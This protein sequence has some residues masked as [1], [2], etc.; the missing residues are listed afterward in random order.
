[1]PVWASVVLCVSLALGPSA[2]AQRVDEGDVGVT[3]VAARRSFLGAGGGVARR[4]GQAR[5]AVS[6]TLGS[7]AGAAAFRFSGTADF[8]LSPEARDRTP[9]AGLGLSF[10]GV[11]RGAGAGYLVA[12]L[13]LE[14]RP[15][16]RR[17]WY[18]EAGLGGGVWA[19]AG[20]RWRH[21]PG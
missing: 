1:M 2:S 4:A 18:V 19:A 14:A 3:V 8:V 6:A 5:V 10:A 9:Y 17:G 15:A 13:G 12:V 16:E 11:R 7:E 21:L 20:I